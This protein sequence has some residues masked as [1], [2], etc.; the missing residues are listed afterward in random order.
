MTININM[1]TIRTRQSN[2]NQDD[3]CV[4]STK[5]SRTQIAIEDIEVQPSTSKSSVSLQILESMLCVNEDQ[6]DSTAD[7]DGD[8][9]HSKI[10]SHLREYKKEKDCLFMRIPL[11]GGVSL[12]EYICYNMLN[13]SH[14]PLSSVNKTIASS[15]IKQAIPPSDINRATPPPP[16]EQAME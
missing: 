5:R 12:L 10:Q 16:E 15:S 8:N 7:D 11:I 13:S 6:E 4:P 14:N 1:N 2:S 9:L 3:D